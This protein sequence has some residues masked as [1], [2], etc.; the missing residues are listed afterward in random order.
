MQELES[1]YSHPCPPIF[2][3]LGESGGIRQTRQLSRVSESESRR[4]GAFAPGLGLQL[5][6]TPIS[7][8]DEKASS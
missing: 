8:E 6:C 1:K 7:A 4:G 5:S 3:S 2:R